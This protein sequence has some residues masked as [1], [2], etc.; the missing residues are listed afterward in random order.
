MAKILVTQ[1]SCVFAVIIFVLLI[2]SVGLLV[3]VLKGQLHHETSLEEAVVGH[4]TSSKGPA[5][6]TAS[7]P[8]ISSPL[9]ESQADSAGY[10]LQPEESPWLEF[11]LSKSVIPLHYDLL[12]HPDLDTDTFSGTVEITTNVTQETRHFIVHAYKLSVRNVRVVDVR[13]DKEVPLVKQFVYSPHEYFVVATEEKVKVGTYRLKYEFAGTLNGTIIG[14]YKSRYLATSKFQPTYARRAFPCFDEPSFKATFS[15]ALVHNEGHVALSNMPVELTDRYASDPRLMVTKFQK[16]V[17]MVT[18]LVCFIV[19]DFQF[20]GTTT[21]SGKPFRVYTT[22]DQV[23]L[24]TYALHFGSRVLE[25]FERYFN[26]GY[27]LPKQDMVGIPDFSSGAMEHWGVITFRET[28]LLY[29]PH[30]A[31]PQNLQRISS[32][33]SHEMTHMWF[34]NLVTMSWWDDLWLNEGFASYVEYKGVDEQHPQWDTLSQ[35]VTEELQP[36]MNLDSTL[37]SHP[38]VQPVLHP[39]EITEIFDDISYGKGASVLRMLEFF[40]GE[41]NFKT[42]ISNFLKKHQYRNAKTGDLWEELEVTCG[43]QGNRSISDIMRTWTEQ[44]GFPY[45]TVSRRSENEST[46]FV[47][48]QSRFLKN[49][50]MQTPQAS[51]PYVWSVPLSYRTG[52]GRSGIV[53][54][55]DDEEIEFSVDAKPSTWVKFNVNQTGF[56]LINYQKAEWLRFSD[57]LRTDHQALTPTDRSNLLFDSF[58]L[59]EA[60]HVPLHLFLSM[61]QYLMRETHL[62]PWETAYAS[63]VYLCQMLEDTQVNEVLKGYIR[64]LTGDLYKKL[65]WRTSENHLDNLLRTTIIGLACHSGN[66]ECLSYAAELFQNWTQGQEVPSSLRSLVYNFGMSEM[67]REEHWNYMWSRYLQEESAAQKKTLMNGLAHVRKPYLIL[68]YL[69]YAMDPEKVRSQDFFTILSYIAGNPVGRPLVWN[70]IRDKWPALVDRFTLNNRYLGNAVKKICSYFTT[71]KQLEEMRSFFAK[72]PDAGA[73]KRRRQQALE[74]VQNNIRWIEGHVQGLKEWLEV[75]GPVPWYSPRLPAHIIPEHY[76]L[77]LHPNLTAE[78]FTGRVSIWVTLQRPADRLLVHAGKQLNVSE[79]QVWSDRE[80]DKSERIEIEEV[81]YKE[82]NEYLVLKTR[83]K[84]SFGQYRLYFEFAGNMA[85]SLK[86]LYKSWYPDLQTQQRK[87]LA[88]TQFA[89]NHA[90]QVF[91]CFDEPSYRATFNVSVLHDAAMFALFNA[92]AEK[93]EEVL[94][95][96]RFEKSMPMST[97]MLTLVVCNFPFRETL[98]ENGVRVRFYTAPQHLE[99]AEY[100]LNSASKMLTWYEKYFGVPFPLKKLDLVAIPDLASSVPSGHPRRPAAGAHVVRWFGDGGLVGRVVAERRILHYISR[101]GAEHVEPD[102]D[103]EDDIE[104]LRLT[105]ALI[106]D[107]T[108]HSHPIVQRVE[109]VNGFH[110]D[111]KC[112]KGSSILRMLENYIGEDFRDGISAYLTRHS[113][114]NARM[115]DVWNAFTFNSRQRLDVSRMMETWTKQMNYPYLY[116]NCSDVENCIIQQH[117]FLEDL[118]TAQLSAKPTPFDYVWHIPLTYRTSNSSEVT[119]VLLNSTEKGKWKF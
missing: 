9:P 46:F 49:Q 67:G 75:E 56:F 112:K 77:H 63:F 5:S 119:H 84:L 92:P 30:N 32:V 80:G 8:V 53:W 45:V 17:P 55:H 43:L 103:K 76:D 116:V 13:S 81:F 70:F 15:V 91:P 72:Y 40:V 34:G 71:E 74:A 54:I 113:F 89:P 65:G 24:T 16:S 39:D 101:K 22:P 100:A 29:D 86:G 96:S 14:F 106:A 78:S 90:R 18:Y 35:F 57:L 6:N 97:H 88:V 44:M 1:P 98:S 118:E 94:K 33:I 52:E 68:R 108:V 38:I 104:L 50:D 117:R 61:S 115:Q 107:R 60:G 19:S 11:R 42:G 28:N 62:I 109:K 102:L 85:L 58:L 37:S 3:F 111:I 66:Q 99:K 64:D 73:G 93:T 25:Y 36:V 10:T 110:D 20:Q 47:A 82:D 21:S 69:D 4:K 95:L 2:F 79:A 27:P 105:D 51:V 87:F 59:A 48:R 26:I 23:N 83:E 7:P 12:L 114:G 41:D 31:S